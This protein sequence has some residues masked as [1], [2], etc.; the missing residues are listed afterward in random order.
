M[1]YAN[2][3]DPVHGNISVE[4]KLIFDLI[5]TREMQR[6]R[7]IKQL[8]TASFTYLGAEHTRLAHS[9]GVFY[10]ASQIAAKLQ[11][12][13]ESWNSYDTEL[14]QVA[15][16]LHDVGHGAFS[17]T[18]E[19][20]FGTN[21]EEI[22][23][24]IITSPETEVNQVLESYRRGFAQDVADVIAHT[25]RRKAVVDLISSQLDADRM[26]YLLRDAYFT[27]A[28]YVKF[29]KTKIINSMTLVDNRI[30]FDKSALSD[31]ESFIIGRHQMYQ[32]VYF[33]KTNRAA[34]VLLQ[35]ML[36]RAKALYPEQ[37][38]YFRMTA[39]RLV[40]FFEN[41]YD[42][43]DY[44]L[45]D[46]EVMNAIFSLWSTS[47]DDILQDLAQRYVTRILPKSVVFD[48]PESD[49]EALREILIQNGYDIEYYT[50]VSKAYDLPYDVYH[51]DVDNPRTEIKIISGD[52]TVSE[53]SCVSPL[54][55]A[56]TS[57][58]YGDKRFY[59]PS[60]MKTDYSV[61]AYSPFAEL[62]RH[63]VFH[64]DKV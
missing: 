54:V 47:G 14:A 10:L 56:L 17:H 31:V 33:N 51:N 48:E 26:D 12:E 5:S 27:G 45:L 59:F 2:F 6:L 24:E 32:N 34:V 22:T 25:S 64:H 18:F 55:R 43:Q 49:L 15:G 8:S 57:I 50:E 52:M 19:Q 30:V 23:C 4:S 38:D 46:D 63:G 20:L 35:N 28:S 7:H 60:E 44:L 39:P 9:V 13:N 61:K 40:P 36:K 16:L 11:N 37:R 3:I 21:H 1:N 62:T 53:L 42:L 41:N 58:T 29:D